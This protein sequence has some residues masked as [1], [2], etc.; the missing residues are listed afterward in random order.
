MRLGKLVKQ[1]VCTVLAIEN[2]NCRWEME[3]EMMIGNSLG[4]NVTA[5][6][7][8]VTIAHN[9]VAIGQGSSASPI[10]SPGGK[11]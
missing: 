8:N 11:Q 9:V 7:S 3:L 10:P 6:V 2:E 5:E 4:T 1:G